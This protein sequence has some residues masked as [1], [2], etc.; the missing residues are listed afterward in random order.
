MAASI[1]A[2]VYAQ[3][4]WADDPP[5]RVEVSPFSLISLREPIELGERTTAYHVEIRQAGTWNRAPMDASGAEVRGT[6]IGQRQLWQLDVTTAEAVALVI[7]DAKDVPAIVE[8]G[9]Y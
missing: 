8:F 5:P 6:L 3:T 1:A 4:A 7:D 2:L 9:L